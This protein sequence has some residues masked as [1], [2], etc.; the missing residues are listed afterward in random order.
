MECG[1]VPGVEQLTSANFT[2]RPDNFVHVPYDNLEE[3]KCYY[4][5]NS[6]PNPFYHGKYYGLLSEKFGDN[7]IDFERFAYKHPGKKWKKYR[8]LPAPLEIPKNLIV[9]DFIRFYMEKPLNGG[10]RIT[11][12]VK[13]SKRKTRRAKKSKRHT[14]KH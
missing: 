14:R 6:D 7:M 5:Y 13:Y 3:D 12:R 10:K 1:S 8:T 9:S 2:D 11:R 4:I